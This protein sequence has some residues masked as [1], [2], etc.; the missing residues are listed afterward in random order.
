MTA[1][2]LALAAGAVA[3]ALAWWCAG[4]LA[5]LLQRDGRSPGADERL[6]VV[7][8]AA[9]V[10]A[11]VQLASVLLAWDVS[12]RLLVLA[13]VSVLAASATV[14]RVLHAP[15]GRGVRPLV[16]RVTRWLLESTGRRDDER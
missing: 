11:L 13:S 9:V 5:M 2:L 15:E 1:W 12:A 8:L 6:V 3:M 7:L 16:R 14:V 10:V 4:G